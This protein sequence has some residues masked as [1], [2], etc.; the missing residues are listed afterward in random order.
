MLQDSVKKHFVR[1]KY[2]AVNI[3]VSGICPHKPK[4][5]SDALAAQGPIHAAM[6]RRHVAEIAPVRELF[7]KVAE[8]VATFARQL[9]IN[10]DMLSGSSLEKVGNSRFVLDWIVAATQQRVIFEFN[11]GSHCSL[12]RIQNTLHNAQ[13]SPFHPGPHGH[14]TNIGLGRN[15][16]LERLDRGFGINM[17][18]K[19]GIFLVQC[20]NQSGQVIRLVVRHEYESHAHGSGL[21]GGQWQASF[22]QL[23]F[24]G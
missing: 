20:S 18:K 4:D 24:R 10:A 23:D 14:K 16:S 17:N 9:A 13:F 15:Q 6:I 22:R 2:L 1:R 8:F 19:T 5:K 11:S 12:Q 7:E 21:D 3:C